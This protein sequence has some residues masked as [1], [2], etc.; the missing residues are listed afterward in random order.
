[1]SDASFKVSI[2]GCG[3]VGV[4]AAYAM[5]IKG[6]PTEVIL[7]SRD[8]K[9]AEGEKLDLEHSLPF[10]KTAKIVASDS[11][12][13]IAGSKIVIVTAG[14]AQQPG[15]TRI[16]LLN[17]NIQIIDEIIP[18]ILH[19]APHAIILIV[20]NPVDL[21][22]Q[23]AV[24]IARVRSG[25][26]FGSGTMLDSARFRF[27]LSES[28]HVNA[29][30]IHAYILGEHG[31]SSFPAVS[32][33][34]IGGQPLF[35]YPGCSS[36]VIQQSFEKAQKAAYHIIEAKG[37]TYYAIGAVILKVL[38]NILYDSSSVLPV[39]IPISNY[40][41]VFDV[42]LSVPCIVG[43]RGVQQ[44]LHTELSEPEQQALRYSADVLKT[45]YKSIGK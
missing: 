7:I 8:R 18:K 28:L 2:V 24:E 4:T 21:L 22:T 5:L 39:S 37:A 17:R 11:Y 23:R 16:E 1:M 10:L 19:A 9:K 43:S 44:I 36:E 40:Y 12:E 41:G 26:I 14:V 33:A 31:D 38:D 25:Q 27:H 3:N 29:R 35:T 45:I 15:E 20:S 34:T 30:S 32:A 42:S 6:M 13:E